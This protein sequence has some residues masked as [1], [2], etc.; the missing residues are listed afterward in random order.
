MEAIPFV[1][2]VVALI[3]LLLFTPSLVLWLP[4]MAFG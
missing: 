1:A 4:N 2:T 3:V